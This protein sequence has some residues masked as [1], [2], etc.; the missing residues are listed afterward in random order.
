MFPFVC[1]PNAMYRLSNDFSI[2]DCDLLLVLLLML[3]YRLVVTE[4]AKEEERERDRDRKKQQNA[5][6]FNVYNKQMNIFVSYH[7]QF[8]E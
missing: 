5:Y 2:Y 3:L 1:I 4:L 8:D 6:Q 7:I